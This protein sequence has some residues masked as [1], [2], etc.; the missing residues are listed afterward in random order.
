MSRGRNQAPVAIPDNP[1][2]ITFERSDC[3]VPNPP[4]NT[5][6]IVDEDGCINWMKQLDLNDNHSI[7]WRVQVGHQIA[8]DKGIPNPERAVLKDWPANYRFY[9]HH[10]GIENNPRHDI[11]LYG[12]PGKRFRSI[13]EFVPHAIWL[14]RDPQLDV[15]NCACKYCTKRAQRDISSVIFQANAQATSSTPTPGKGS[16]SAPVKGTYELLLQSR[17][18][19]EKNGPRPRREAQ[20]KKAREQA[21]RVYAAVQKV[22]RPVPKA[23]PNVLRYALHS[24]ADNDLRAVYST[25]ANKRQG[26]GPFD[27]EDSVPKPYSG[28]KRWYRTAEIVWCRLPGR[29]IAIPQEVATQARSQWFEDQHV[30]DF[31]PGIV[32]SADVKSKAVPPKPS[33]TING[34]TTTNAQDVGSN[35]QSS[36]GQAPA[37]EVKQRWVYRIRLLAVDAFVDVEEQEV[38]PYLAHNV[39]RILMTTISQ[40]PMQLLDFDRDRVAEFHPINMA[41]PGK[42]KEKA[43]GEPQ[44]IYDA[45]SA[46]A[47]AMQITASASSFWSLTDM[48]EFRYIPNDAKSPSPKAPPLPTRPT[49]PPALSATP[50]RPGASQGMSLGS[51]IEAAG[52]A[53]AEAAKVDY[54]THHDISRVTPS[55]TPKDVQ[56]AAIGALGT[57]G[58]LGL[59]PRR[60]G[61]SVVPSASAPAG[62][63]PASTEG[64]LQ[65]RFQGLWWGPERIWQHDF[66]RLQMSRGALA[67]NGA[68]NVLKPSGPGK[69][70]RAIWDEAESLR[71]KG[72]DEAILRQLPKILDELGA[73]TRG[74]FMRIDALF[75]VD[76]QKDGKMKKEMRASGMLYELA[77]HDFEEDDGASKSK[78]KEAEQR[79]VVNESLLPSTPTKI[80]ATASQPSASQKA[81]PPPPLPTRKPPQPAPSTPYLVP[82]PPHKYKFR[83]ILPPGYE[84]VIS[85]SLIAG[86]YYPSICCHPLIAK[87]LHDSLAS[88]RS[89]EDFK[90]LWSLEGLYP[91]HENASSPEIYKK[92]RTAMIEDADNLATEQLTDFREGKI[93]EREE[94]IARATVLTM[95]PRGS[96]GD[97]EMDEDS[98]DE[99]NYPSAG[100]MDVD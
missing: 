23:S 75:A 85:L 66:V 5:V 27:P 16:A 77:D 25:A 69:S 74:T 97:V 51:A 59:S 33:S 17:N 81:T 71:E 83:P 22:L 62:S 10:K 15:S 70:T 88:G 41:Q 35:D 37:W 55:A 11:Y 24:E 21:Q 49:I 87:S 79:F 45:L 32:E 38:L 76:V 84:A 61:P 1:V 19:Y 94:A 95:Q 86:R 52:R 60:H 64:A 20:P 91:G 31:W 50:P 40:L 14:M 96:G 54:Y 99:L 78:G 26:V 68:P 90:N 98:A 89:R 82:Q 100:D 6:R 36:N 48:Y 63:K 7:K 39:P 56:Q 43:T 29:G 73:V 42:G 18:A 67:P 72:S 13:M 30:I 2:W 3:A 4:P 47:L 28:L 9:D 57:P 34:S 58:Y 53:N 80:N 93:R 8:L 46:F 65:T 92:N 44:T 12:P